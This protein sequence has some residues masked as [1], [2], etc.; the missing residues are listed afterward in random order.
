MAAIRALESKSREHK[1]TRHKSFSI[2]GKYGK[3][4]KRLMR[5]LVSDIRDYGEI[6]ALAWMLGFF[7]D[8]G[9]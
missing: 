8:M 6:V 5:E 9:R 4:M 2:H 7:A 1:R 3:K